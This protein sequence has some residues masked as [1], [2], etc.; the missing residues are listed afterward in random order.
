LGG[1]SH[2]QVAVGAYTYGL[3]RDSFFA[4][5]PRRSC[6]F[7][8]FL[9]A[10][11]MGFVSCLEDIGQ[12]SSPLSHFGRFAFGE[13]PHAEALSKGDIVVGHDVWIG[14]NAMIL[15]GVTI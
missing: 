13:T 9:A 15:S 4:Y 7:G 14:R 10:S 8:N 2:P 3:R 6:P 5:H 12:T 11:Q 1:F